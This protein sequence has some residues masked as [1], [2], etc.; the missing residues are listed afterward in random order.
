MTHPT[1]W[2]HHLLDDRFHALRPAQV[3]P[4]WPLFRLEDQRKREK[5]TAPSLKGDELQERVRPGV[6][7]WKTEGIAIC[8]FVHLLHTLEDLV[9]LLS[10]C[11]LL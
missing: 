8:Q 11:H 6:T 1:L 9:D 7:S 10:S 4:D 2:V 3:E 5:G